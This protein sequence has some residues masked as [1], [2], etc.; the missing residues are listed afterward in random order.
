MES[1]KKFNIFKI[2][3]IIACLILFIGLILPYESAIGEHK[4]YLEKNPDKMNIKEVNIT[5]K[6]A[7]DISI[8]ENFRVYSY[9]MNNNAGN[10]WIAQEST[11]NFV[12]TIVLI[13]SSI[14]VLLFTLFN[15]RVLSII[16]DI[17]LF[18]SSI[19]MNFDIVSRGVIPSDKY[20]YGISYYLYPVLAVI[21]LVAT[22]VLIVKNKKEKI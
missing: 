16:F 13:A 20:T 4:E 7:V 2:I 15:K 21:I 12:L 5:N 18:G 17:L 6:D 3:I 11:I 9:G 19:M 8:I 14:L 1:I 22:I 10:S